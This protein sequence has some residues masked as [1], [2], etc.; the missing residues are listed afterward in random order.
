[1]GRR[2]VEFPCRVCVHAALKW[3]VRGIPR[4]QVR[5]VILL[6][7]IQRKKWKSDEAL[8]AAWVCA[9]SRQGCWVFLS[10]DFSWL[11]IAVPPLLPNHRHPD[12]SGLIPHR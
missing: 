10:W 5:S 7:L 2:I 4:N 11:E 8:S 9:G 6:F 12:L 3:F 1:M